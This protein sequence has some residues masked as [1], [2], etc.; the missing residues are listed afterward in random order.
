MNKKAVAIGSFIMACNKLAD[1]R[2]GKQ[3]LQRIVGKSVFYKSSNGKLWF[4][5]NKNIVS[6]TIPELEKLT[7]QVRSAY[8]SL[9]AAEYKKLRKW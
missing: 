6:K 1:E 2:G 7:D 9:K 5:N 8:T 4:Y 3:K